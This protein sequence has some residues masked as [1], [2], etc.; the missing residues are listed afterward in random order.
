MAQISVT[1]AGRV[2]RMAC[3][4]GEEDRLAGLAAQVDAKIAEMRAGF[5]EIG[6]Q[7]LTVMAAITFADQLL[8]AEKKIEALQA[9]A[10]RADEERRSAEET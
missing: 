3:E 7:R 2:Y 4:D 6:D 9:E 10:A 5:G 1:I 8:E